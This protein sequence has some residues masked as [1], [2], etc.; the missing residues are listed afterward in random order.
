MSLPNVNEIVSGGKVSHKDAQGDPYALAGSHKENQRKEERAIQAMQNAIM[1]ETMPAEMKTG[2]G[3]DAALINHLQEQAQ[4]MGLDLS[5]DLGSMSS[6]SKRTKKGLSLEQQAQLLAVQKE[7]Q[8]EAMDLMIAEKILIHR[9]ISR[10]VSSEQ[11]GPMLAREGFTPATI[12]ASLP[13]LKAN[14]LQAKS[15]VGSTDTKTM[16]QVVY[17]SSQGVEKLLHKVYCVDGV[18][19][20][21][22]RDPSFLG[23][24]EEAIIDKL[25][26][27]SFSH[28]LRL[29]TTTL[30]TAAAVHQVHKHN[31]KNQFAGHDR[32]NNPVPEDTSSPERSQP[33]A[34]EKST[35]PPEESF[36]PPVRQ[37]PAGESKTHEVKTPRTA[38]GDIEN[39]DT[40]SVD[41]TAIPPT[42]EI[43]N[44][45]DISTASEHVSEAAPVPE[46]ESEE[47][48]KTSARR[49]RRRRQ[50]HGLGA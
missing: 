17:R 45:D 8:Q 33:A 28:W 16:M 37:L 7:Q 41:H 14:L 19:D 3:G 29:A 43:K 9:K 4:K 49:N 47:E 6:T 35:E 50:R 2:R 13:D 24:L 42:D 22:F 10:Y 48:T 46:S 1:E 27:A 26:Q 25:S 12:K 20:I 11:F 5:E 15:I 36:Y 39:A 40:T 30:T 32:Q 18:T 34:E 38:R 31:A 21:L 23:P 44:T